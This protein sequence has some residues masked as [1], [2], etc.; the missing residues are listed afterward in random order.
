LLDR[1][2]LREKPESIAQA[3]KARQ[4]DLNISELIDLDKQWRESV[5][6]VEQ[7]KAKRNQVSQEIANKK[8]NQ[9]SAEEDILAMR[10]VGE[11]IKKLTGELEELE[12]SFNQAWLNIPNIP[13]ASVPIGPDE[14]ANQ[15]IRKW[16]EPPKLN[17]TAN[18]HWVLGDKLKM[19]DAERAA[20]ISGARFVV[21]TGIGARLE[22][23]LIQFMLD[24]QT[25]ENGYTEIFPP[26]LVNRETMIGTGQLPK[27]EEDMFKTK[28]EELFLIPTAEVPVTNLHSKEILKKEELPIKYTAYTP[29]FR[30]EAGSYGKDTKGL[31]RQHQ[32]NKVE[33]VK[34]VAPENSYEELEKL[35]LDAE[36]IL[37]KLG[38][39]YRL[40]CLSTG[41]MSFASSKSYDLEVWHAG[42]ARYWEVS[43]CSNFENFQARRANIRFKDEQGKINFCHTLNGSGLATSRL[44]PAIIENY[45]TPEGGIIIPEVLRPY[46]GEKKEITANGELI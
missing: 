4:N 39:H 17:F 36:K 41:D 16:G 42:V 5:N 33:L 20:K 22:R 3:L 1:K 6:K 27:L 31:V 18:P 38:L 23:A 8:K 35:V 2:I 30:R 7:L 19:F 15:E 40:V 13:H 43:S 14:T 32:F 21:Y 12:T 24:V 37:Q 9:Q 11:E 44:L 28:E 34:I 10:K 26:L 25:Q 29:C 45:Q 46:L